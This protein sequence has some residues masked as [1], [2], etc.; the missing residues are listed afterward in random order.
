MSI[1]WRETSLFECKETTIV[2]IPSTEAEYVAA[3]RYCASMLK[4]NSM[5]STEAEYVAAAG[6]CASKTVVVKVEE[7]EEEM[8]ETKIKDDDAYKDELL[9]YEEGD[10]QAPYSAVV[11]YTM[12]PCASSSP[13]DVPVASL[14][15][16]AKIECIADF[17]APATSSCALN[18]NEPQDASLSSAQG[19]YTER[20]A[21]AIML[22]I[23][24]VQ[25]NAVC[26]QTHHRCSRAATTPLT[27]KCEHQQENAKQQEVEQGKA[28]GRSPTWFSS[29]RLP[30]TS[31]FLKL[32]V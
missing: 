27:L 15:L 1:T 14:P 25:D 8:G 18:L 10:E 7:E 12:F 29:I 24:E 9:D 26:R 30:L 28:K 22:T 31:F 21:V 17:L 13:L 20:T 4:L 5:S 3:A 2:A 6:Y 19:H 16:D 11:N 32:Q 23:V